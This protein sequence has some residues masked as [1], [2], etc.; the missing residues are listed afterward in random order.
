MSFTRV[1]TTNYMDLKI[2]RKAGKTHVHYLL[3]L[4]QTLLCMRIM[5][6]TVLDCL[7]GQEERY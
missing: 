5:V 1:E 2:S 4:Q 7:W 6:E 3:V